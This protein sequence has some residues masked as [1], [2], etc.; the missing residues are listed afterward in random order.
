MAGLNFKDLM[1]GMGL[2]PHQ[3][4]AGGYA[5]G[6]L[7]LECSGVVVSMGEEVEGFQRGDEVMAVGRHCFGRY[8]AIPAAFAVKKPRNLSLE[9]AAGVPVA[10]FTASYALLHLGDLKEGQ[11]VLIHGAAG[12]VGLAA[13]QIV[14]NSGGEVFATAGSDEKRSYLKSLGIRYVMDSRS[15]D[16]ADEVMESTHGEGVDMVLNC[17]SGDSLRKS[18]GLLRPFGRFLDISR[19]DMAENSRLDMQPFL[20]NLS[21]FAIYLDQLWQ[22]DRRLARALFEQ[23]RAQLEE[24]VLR[25]LPYRVFPA[26]RIVEAFRYIQQSKHIGKVVVSMKDPHCRVLDEVRDQ[27]RLSSHS[28]YLVPVRKSVTN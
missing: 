5:G 13:I 2:L 16:F 19:R 9:E 14:Q 17:L 18:L 24:G 22:G 12:G 6:S 11:R 26:S 20:N 10:Y 3:A 25:P 28:S 7:G 8:V 21:Y 23:L 27:V 15:L 1:I 4:L